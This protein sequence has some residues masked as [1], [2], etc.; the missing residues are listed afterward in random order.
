M[1][2]LK[3]GFTLAEVLIT[4]GVIGVVAAMTIPTLIANINGQRY[5]SQFKKTLSTLNQAGRMAQA[6]YDFSFADI[7]VQG[8]R[9]TKEEIEK[10]NP[11]TEKSLAAILNGT[12]TGITY[13]IHNATSDAPYKQINATL[14]KNTLIGD[15]DGWL[16]PDGA[17]VMFSVGIDGYCDN[18]DERCE[19][20]IDVNG[21]SLPNKE[22][23][24]SSGET[25][26]IWNEDYEECVV[27]N[28][29]NDMTDIFPIVIYKNQVIPATNAAK[30]VLDTTK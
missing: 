30:Y 16:L 15:Y 9:Q 12:I 2:N 24:C 20:F 11:E 27:K 5:R 18:L 23:S 10:A 8:W 22:V 26:T 13:I 3:N 6:Q 14:T 25:K 4:L 28:N 21:I 7:D 29:A 19:G 17:L 1:K